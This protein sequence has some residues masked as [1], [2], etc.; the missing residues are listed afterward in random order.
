MLSYRHGFHVGNH[1]DVVKHVAL[2]QLLRALQK[3]E[4]GF[5]YIDTHAGAGSYR[6]DSPEALKTGEFRD[7]I[8]RV[9][10]TPDPP[11]V[12]ADYLE[13][14]RHTN[15]GDT[16]ERYPGSPLIAR[17]LLRPSD[18]AVLC[19]MHPADAEQLER[20]FRGDRAVQVSREDGHRRLPALLPPPERRGL[21]LMDP[22][23]EVKSE[24]RMVVDTLAEAHR[25]WATGI[26]ALWYPVVSRAMVSGMMGAF[27]GLGIRKMLR[28]ELGVK[29]DAAEWGMTG[30]GLL[31]INPPWHFDEQMAEALAWLEP[32]LSQQPGSYWTVDWLVPE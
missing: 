28:L 16:L 30:S 25:R 12:I 26:Y 29:P 32:S 21:V 19:E 8:G 4:K 18:R 22:A 3:K 11:G 14:V 5:V 7:G 17:Q 13:R 9:A 1:G 24:Y 2:A 15:I 23:Y 6:L 20:L 27:T 10:E 31:V